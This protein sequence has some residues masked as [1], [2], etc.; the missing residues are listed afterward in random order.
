MQVRYVRANIRVRPYH[1][2]KFNGASGYVCA[3]TRQMVTM[4]WWRA[5][6]MIVRNGTVGRTYDFAPTIFVSL[7]A[8]AV[9]FVG[10][11]IFL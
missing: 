5:A 2:R 8:Q 4:I 9:T 1:L 6:I 7:V 10:D 3:I 11:S